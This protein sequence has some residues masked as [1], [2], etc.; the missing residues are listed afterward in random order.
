MHSVKIEA[1]FSCSFAEEDKNVNDYFLSICRALDIQCSNVS[2]SYTVT[3]PQAAKEKISQAQTLIAICTRRKR[4]DNGQFS[5]PSAVHD[6]ISF[7]FGKDI[8]VLMFVENEVELEGFKENFGTHLVFDR[9]TLFTTL[10]MEKIISSI[11]Q[12]KMNIVSPNDIILSQDSDEFYAE[13]INHLVELKEFSGE[14]CWHNSTT[15]K[16]VFNKQFKKNLMAGCWAQIPPSEGDVTPIIWDVVLE[17]S[18]NNITID[19]V[20]EK[21]TSLCVEA[22][23][24]FF[25]PPERGDFVEYSVYSS[26][27]N[28]NAIWLEDVQDSSVVHLDSG[29]YKCVDGLIMIHR[30]KK[31]LIEF[32][33]PKKFNGKKIDFVPFVASYTSGIDF[34]V[35]SELKRIKVESE[36]FGG[37]FTLKMSID[38]PLLRH[39]YGIA[40]NP[41]HKPL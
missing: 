4:I 35:E 34:E 24:R 20:K 21:C 13:Y 22:T 8:P 19:C 17:D 5:M 2:T 10:S 27:R 30:T 36:S 32:R 39:V 11:H 12:L 40:W 16:L 1:F 15:K 31:A 38:S 6:E 14:Y 29:D 3:P 18:S 9:S 28:L 23:I 7:A 25:P 26:S 41:K 33:F 37:N